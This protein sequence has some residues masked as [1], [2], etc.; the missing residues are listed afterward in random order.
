MSINPISNQCTG[1]RREFLWQSGSGFTG[2]ALTAMLE[3]DGFFGTT[4]QASE[5]QANPLT[6][7]PIPKK[8]KSCIFLF[9]F[10]GPSQVDLFDYK[11]ELQK[12]DGQTID[13]EF[14]RNVKTK[15]VLQASRRS[16]ARHGQSGQWCSDAFPNISRHMD[17]LA[18]IKSLYSDSFAHGSAVLQMN[19]GRILQGHPSVGAWLSHGMGSI[20]NNLPTHMIM[21][22]PR[23]GP[24]TGAPNWSSGYMPAMHQGTVLR[25]NGPP[26]LNLEPG[27]GM[28]HSMQRQQL[29]FINQLNAEHLKS[30]PEFSELQARVASYEL[31]FKLQSAAPEAL[32]LSTESEKTREMYGLNDKKG[33]HPLTLGPAPFG[34]QCLTA[35]RLV[36]RGVRFIQIYSG[37]GGAGGQNTWDG[38]QGIEENLTIHAPEVDK[39]IAALLTDLEQRGLLDETLVVWGG[40]FGRMPVSET[41][42]TGGKPGGRDHNPKGFTYWMAGAGIKAGTSYGETDDFGQDAVVNRH[43]LRDL[44]A[45]ILHLMGLDHRKLTYFYG[46]LENKLTGVQEAQVI[47]GLLS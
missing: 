38:H 17:K 27:Q 13:N 19:T 43:H 6:N 36:E 2:L 12:R 4:A 29:Q 16:F 44:H 32:D 11:P 22:D 8:A 5:I 47:Q 7:N 34:R 37:G 26:I 46:G 24:T 23:G 9:M 1:S 30:R 33:D 10:G 42:N 15:A 18:V 20:N 41:F 40:E 45:T 25:T 3:A 31:A 14:R 28:T 39:P 21:L 35:R